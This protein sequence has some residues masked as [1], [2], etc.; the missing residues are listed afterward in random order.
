MAIF[1][2]NFDA[3]DVDFIVFFTLFDQIGIIKM[4]NVDLL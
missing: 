3:L 1:R 2:R 4:L